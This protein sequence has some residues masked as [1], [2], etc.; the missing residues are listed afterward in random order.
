MG[1]TKP[2]MNLEPFSIAITALLMAKIVFFELVLWKERSSSCI[3]LNSYSDIVLMEERIILT[4]IVILCSCNRL[5]IALENPNPKTPNNA[6]L[7]ATY[8]AVNA[9]TAILRNNGDYKFK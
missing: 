2:R 7:R 6:V 9:F 4:I 8:S 1:D 3:L 5:D